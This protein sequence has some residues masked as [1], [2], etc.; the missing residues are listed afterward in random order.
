MKELS[1]YA[2][3]PQ[4]PAGYFESGLNK[5][6]LTMRFSQQYHKVMFTKQF[7]KLAIKSYSLNLRV[8]V[9]AFMFVQQVY[10]A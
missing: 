4:L 10:A 5:S 9:L 7:L 8:S 1:S 6:C 2:H 3:L